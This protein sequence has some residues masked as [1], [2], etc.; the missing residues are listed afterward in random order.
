MPAAMITLSQGDIF[1]SGGNQQVRIPAVDSIVGK[2]AIAIFTNI[3]LA[4]S[5]TVQ[6]FL[7]FDDVIKFI[8][9]GKGVG[10]FTVEGTMYCDCGGSLP[11]LTYYFNAI[12]SLRG[13]PITVSLLGGSPAIVAVLVDTSVRVTGDPDTI[14]D[15]TLHFSIVNHNI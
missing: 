2:N 8:H 13:K 7:T 5:E 3:T 1:K 14:G 6:Y 9:F 10:S 12:S 4:L 15:F 11:G